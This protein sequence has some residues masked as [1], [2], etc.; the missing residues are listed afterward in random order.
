MQQRAEA[1]RLYSHV[2][3]PPRVLS[4]TSVKSHTGWIR[5]G[6]CSAYQLFFCFLLSLRALPLAFIVVVVFCGY[7]CIGW[8]MLDVGPS[9]TPCRWEKL[10]TRYNTGFVTISFWEN[11]YNHVTIS[12]VVKMRI[13]AGKGR[14]SE[15]R[16]AAAEAVFV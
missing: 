4:E 1:A 16:R 7:G 9:W 12:W 2:T 10:H 13:G 6:G 8:A 14:R 11:E 15:G 5:N 3:R